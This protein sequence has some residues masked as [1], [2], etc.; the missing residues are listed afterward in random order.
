MSYT[1]FT[2][3]TRSKKLILAHIEAREKVKLFQVHDEAIYK[4]SVNHFVVGLKDNGTDL[5]EVSSLGA[6]VAGSWYFDPLE[7]VV[8]TWI[9]GGVDP[10]TRSIYLTYR[11]FFSNHGAEHYSHITSG[12]IVHYDARIDDIGD[13]KLELDYENTG[14]ALETNSSIQFMNNDGYFDEIFDTLIFENQDATFYSWSDDLPYTSAK[15]IY[16]GVVSEKSFTEK[17]VKFTLKDQLTKL[18][19]TLEVSRFSEEDGTL[20]DA[21]I[22]KPKRIIFG[23]VDRIRTHG[24]DK[25]GDGFAL[26]GTISG[27]A[28][29]NLLEGTAQAGLGSTTV[30]GVGTSFIGNIA[31]GNQLTFKE[32]LAEYTYTVSSI[33]SDTVL[34]LTSPTTAAFNLASIRNISTGSS[35][36]PGTVA[37]TLGASALTGTTTTFT[38]SLRVGAKIK[39]T[40]SGNE[41]DNVVDTITSNTALTLVNPLTVTVP[42]GSKVKLVAV[43][44]NVIEGSG[45]QF[46]KEV[47]PGDKIKIIVNLEEVEYSVSSVESDTSLTIGDEIETTFTGFSATNFPEINYRHKNRRWNIAGH[48]LRQ[49]T[50]VITFK[51][52]SI[53]FQVLEIGD[54]ESGDKL[55]ILGETYIV[56][57]VSGNFVR[58]NQGL[59]T[60]VSSGTEVTKIP[61]QEVYFGK[62]PLVADRDY[63]LENGTG[64]AVVVIDPLAEFN[65]AVPKNPSVQFNMTSVSTIV[66]TSSTL[67]DITA[68]IKPRDWIRA[69]SISL[70]DWYEVLAVEKDTIYLRTPAAATYTGLIQ[71]K[72]PEYIGDESLIAASCLGY[73]TGTKWLRYPSDIVAWLLEQIGVDNINQDSFDETETD[74]PYLMS[75]YYPST[76]GSEVPNIQEMI[77]DVNKSVFG[78]LYLNDSFEFSYTTLNADRGE[79]LESIEDEDIQSF[80]VTSKSNIVS[81]V[82]VS[83][84][85]NVDTLSGAEGFR[86]TKLESDFVNEAVG[87][88]QTLET[89]AYLY[90]SDDADT[91]AQRFLFF[92]SLTQSIVK[93]KSKLNLTNKSLNDRVFLDLA[94]LYKRFAGRDRR[95][96]GI[97]NSIIKDGTGTEVEFNDLGNIFN[98]VASITPN[99]VSSWDPEDENVVKYGFVL[100]ND[101][102]TPDPTSEIGLG[103]NLMG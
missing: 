50:T 32:G 84:S 75:L 103:S 27:S 72:N 101:T 100:D 30:N 99:T 40:V 6:L 36:I 58:V 91:I 21:M 83:Y 9:P 73:G 28:D 78:S 16:K 66:T 43:E 96:I 34:V 35:D 20:E 74:C 54:I 62:T 44:N 7:S 102:E 1:D 89:T 47:S 42:A 51:K 5:Q 80:S 23:R 81:T 87:R 12:S 92:R 68:I 56:V 64:N 88:K 93:V 60:S 70:P 67:V 79:D 69:K 15:V 2:K 59:P 71:F 13:L 25:V 29:R 41:Y 53:N 95:K 26:T 22:G 3:K 18:K 14:I 63:T 45:T 46:L 38:T 61:L 49:S 55:V 57:R 97:I 24:V 85:P 65:V 39:I 76:L 77:T 90:R 98:R 4:R 94:R 8:Y 86:T 11:L 19:Q 52:D 31:P 10:K 17:L 33:T 37:G 82:I 48:K